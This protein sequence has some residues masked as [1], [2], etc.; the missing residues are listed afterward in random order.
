[1]KEFFDFK[2]KNKLENFDFRFLKLVLNQNRFKKKKFFFCFS[3]F[4]SIIKIEKWKMFFEIRFF[5]S[6]QKMKY[7]IVIIILRNPF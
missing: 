6:N 2:S 3:F 4:S 7:E 5:I 1:M